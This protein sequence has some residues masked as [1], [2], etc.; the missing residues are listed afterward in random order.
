MALKPVYKATRGDKKRLIEDVKPGDILYTVHDV[1]DRYVTGKGAHGYEDAQLY[2][3][4]IVTADRSWPS[5]HLM[6][7]SPHS[8]S[9]RGE[10]GVGQLLTRE[11]EVLT[12]QPAGMRNIG[13]NPRAI[14][15][16]EK[17]AERIARLHAEEVAANRAKKA[18]KEPVGAGAGKKRGWF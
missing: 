10:E 12:Q 7:C 4:H 2:S 1:A 16:A 6:T 9:G 3:I 13:D 11:R 17:L 18:A 15:N 5:G 8:T 14:V